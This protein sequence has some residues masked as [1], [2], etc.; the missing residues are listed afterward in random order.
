MDSEDLIELSDEYDAPGWD[1]VDTNVGQEVL[2]G[3]ES[4]F[5][6]NPFDQD[7]DIQVFDDV[8]GYDDFGS[9]FD[10]Y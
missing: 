8:G 4:N 6:H 3:Y 9:S 1:E 5:E 7:Y 10:F 2:E